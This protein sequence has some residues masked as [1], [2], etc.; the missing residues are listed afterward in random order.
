MKPSIHYRRAHRAADALE[1]LTEVRLIRAHDR[2]RKQVSINEL[3][4]RL[5]SKD[6]A[7]ALRLLP[8]TL[9][10]RETAPVETPLRRAFTK[11]VDIGAL[12]I[13]ELRKNG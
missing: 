6:V 4:L 7:S 13:R 10:E 3:A 12:Q 8:R 5:A 1:P 2:I 11:G 9:I